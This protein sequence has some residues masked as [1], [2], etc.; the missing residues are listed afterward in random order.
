[1]K[2]ISFPVEMPLIKKG[3]DLSGMIVSS[4]NLEDK[5]ILLIS[6]TVISKVEGRIAPLSSYTPTE[7]A[8]RIAEMNKEDPR[9]VQAVLEECEDILLETPF[10]LARLHSGYICPNSG[11]DRSNIEK[12]MVILPPEN[13]DK[14]AGRIRKEIHERTGKNVSVVITDT[15]GRAFR[16]GQTGIA[17]GCSGISVTRDWRG[18]KDLYGNVLKIKNEAIVDELAGFAN[19]LMG[20]GDQRTPVVV[21]RGIDLQEEGEGIKEI[22]RPEDEDVIRRALK[23]FQR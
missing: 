6:S 11:V 1:M 13:P 14:S 20:E 23:C 18:K 19:L 16:I 2:I 15:C 7:K 17:V 12:G 21:I 10:I 8:E 5:D 3:D 4:T 22:F 9:F